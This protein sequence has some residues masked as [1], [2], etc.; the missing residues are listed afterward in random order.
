MIRLEY[1]VPTNG[2]RVSFII[3]DSG[4]FPDV[5][6]LFTDVKWPGD[7]TLTCPDTPDNL[8]AIK[9]LIDYEKD[10]S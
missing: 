6:K 5:E 3:R 4:D 1:D 7:G 10:N 8:E 9:Q 2:T